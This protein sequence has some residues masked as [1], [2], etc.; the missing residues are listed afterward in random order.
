MNTTFKLSKMKG[1]NLHDL[2]PHLNTSVQALQCFQRLISKGCSDDDVYSNCALHY[3]ALFCDHEMCTAHKLPN[4]LAMLLE[5]GLN[6]CATD[7]QGR[8]AL[9]F[10]VIGGKLRNVLNLLTNVADRDTKLAREYV[11]VKDCSGW[12]PL[13]LAVVTGQIE[14]LHLL[15]K[16]GGD[17][18]A[19][20]PLGCSVLD[21]AI[22]CFVQC[23]IKMQHS[24]PVSSRTT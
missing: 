19:K 15:V 18:H 16:H 8:T 10:A 9:H 23:L 3:A 11:N 6:P 2:A 7:W 5:Q 21:I 22:I 20:G 14:L 24:A 13:G 1:Y 12:T 4:S 17:V